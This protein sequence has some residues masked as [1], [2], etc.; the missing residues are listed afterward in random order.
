MRTF[1]TSTPASLRSRPKAPFA[2]F[3]LAGAA[4]VLP[5]VALSGCK[6]ADLEAQSAVQQTILKVSHEFADTLAKH[7]SSSAESSISSLSALQSQI[8]R[9]D[10]PSDE[11]RAAAGLLSAAIAQATA[12]VQ[13]VVAYESLRKIQQD[14]AYAAAMAD[15]A[16]TLKTIADSQASISL[17]TD[18]TRL[19]EEQRSADETLKQV[20]DQLKQLEGPMAQLKARIE[21]RR[22]EIVAL[23]GNVEELRRRAIEAGARAGLPLIEE[24]A[25]IKG[26]IRAARAD[27]AIGEL[28][29]SR[30][31]PEHTRANIAHEG[32]KSLK[33]AASSGLDKLQNF[34]NVLNSEAAATR[35]TADEAK[36]SAETALADIA[37]ANTALKETFSAIEANLTKAASSAGSARGGGQSGAQNA[38]FAKLAAQAGLAS[39][40][41]DSAANATSQL[42]LHE[43]LGA[44]GDLFG[45]SAKQA[46]AIASLK[47]ERE[48]MLAK[49][50][51]QLVDAIGQ[52]GEASDNDQ[53][54]VR[55]LRN[56]L[57]GIL[58]R[59]DG[60]AAPTPASGSAGM[61]TPAAASMSSGGFESPEAAIAFMQKPGITDADLP[62]LNSGF[63]ARSE[64]GNA[65]LALLRM[66]AEEMGPAYAAAA[67][68][69][70]DD[71]GKD[72]RDPESGFPDF[73][74]AT[75]KSVADTTAVIEAK[76]QGQPV[77]LQLLKGGA[78]WRLD[79]D[80]LVKAFDPAVAMAFSMMSG[81]MEA[82]RPRLAAMRQSIVERIAS[83]EIATY[84]Q[85]KDTLKTETRE[86]GEAAG[87][88]AA[89]KMMEDLQ[90]Q[91]SGGTEGQ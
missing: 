16:A 87:R 4:T 10:N 24:A 3:L 2:A 54:A 30:V 34:E 43:A 40:Y 41:A 55:G 20:Q 27:A 8:D 88:D 83:G 56:S 67:A 42:Q 31:E 68:K 59:I 38:K 90:K 57:N 18:K 50:K 13:S 9:L 75:V 28:D 82:Q 70:P 35:A 19:R 32:A 22:T 6:D 76:V 33:S 61:A 62:L 26:S 79:V 81:V 48:E 89:K 52:L 1:L 86:L 44:A 23:Q 14:R 17:A 85:F 78:G 47:Q 11:Q 5:L 12:D 84:A 51:E 29:L 64:A 91:P 7:S 39:L 46:D 73:K 66:D 74:D 69:W 15:A 36:K 60:T 49:A 25:G 45:G 53:I 80:S 65:L 63:I 21:E 77:E 58:A 72:S 37:T 71:F